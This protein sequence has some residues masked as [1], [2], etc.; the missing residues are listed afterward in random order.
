[1]EEEDEDIE[2]MLNQDVPESDISDLINENKGNNNNGFKIF[3]IIA[4]VVVVLVVI[5]IIVAVIFRK[6]T[7]E[8][9]KEKPPA[10]PDNC[11]F[12]KY[13]KIENIKCPEKNP[14]NDCGNACKAQI[15]YEP[16][17]PKPDNDCKNG[18]YSFNS[19]K[20][21]CYCSTDNTIEKPIEKCG[22]VLTE[23]KIN[24]K[25]YKICPDGKF[26]IEI[27][28]EGACIPNS[29]LPSCST[30]KEITY[31]AGGLKLVD[32]NKCQAILTNDIK[33]P[34]KSFIKNFKCNN[35]N[36]ADIR[37][38]GCL[39]NGHAVRNNDQEI[40]KCYRKCPTNYEFCP[41]FDEGYCIPIPKN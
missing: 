15:D 5:I 41:I 38:N 23:T 1:M 9:E 6:N 40:I 21:N 11:N 13:P 8:K 14:V 7:E 20:Y 19:T 34:E 4:L 17:C 29:K 18:Q 30:N 12:T 3:G 36:D 27:Q 22:N 26:A 32:N 33:C 25:C 37:I 39:N 16:I 31:C 10:K 28:N 24:G 2:N 35:F